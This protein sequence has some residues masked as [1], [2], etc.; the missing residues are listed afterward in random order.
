MKKE[1]VL[2]LEK[3]RDGLWK[4]IKDVND[5][6]K[7]EA[8]GLLDYHHTSYFKGYV[9]RREAGYIENYRGHFGVGFAVRSPNRHST[10]YSFVSYYVIPE[11]NSKKEKNKNQSVQIV[12]ILF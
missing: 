12:G 10:T 7:L 11:S 8:E 1:K 4:L 5:L 6:D 9:S 3:V 2:E